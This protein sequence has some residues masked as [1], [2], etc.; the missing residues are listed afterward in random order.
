MERTKF[1]TKLGTQLHTK[2]IKTGEKK[3][4][5]ISGYAVR[6]PVWLSRPDADKTTTRR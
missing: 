5:D 4:I 6:N 2:N 1:T 3:V